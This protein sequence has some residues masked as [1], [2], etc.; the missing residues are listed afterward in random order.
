[1][2]VVHKTQTD[3]NGDFRIGAGR[4]KSGAVRNIAGFMPGANTVL[5]KFKI[6]GPCSKPPIKLMPVRSDVRTAGSPPK[7]VPQKGTDEGCHGKIVAAQ[8]YASR[9]FRTPVIS[10]VFSPF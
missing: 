3:K 8:R 1:M 6:G 7:S 4:R 10:M 5:G 2:D 9:R